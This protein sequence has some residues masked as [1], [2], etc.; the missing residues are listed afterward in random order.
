MTMKK[1]MSEWDRGIRAAVGL[2]LMAGMFVWPHTL[3]GLIGIIPFATAVVG[4]CPAYS[5]FG[6]STC[7]LKRE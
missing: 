6:F 7:P 2:I 3:W 4:T 5:L 1:N